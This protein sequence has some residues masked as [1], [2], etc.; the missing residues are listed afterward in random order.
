MVVLSL[1]LFLRPVFKLLLALLLL[2]ALSNFSSPIVVARDLLKPPTTP[3]PPIPPTPSIPPTSLLPKDFNGG[4]LNQ[5][6]DDINHAISSPKLRHP[7][8]NTIFKEPL[9]TSREKSKK[10]EPLPKVSD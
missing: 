8:Y 3:I 10:L 6:F 1:L 7:H 2:S 9:V 4:Y 5:L